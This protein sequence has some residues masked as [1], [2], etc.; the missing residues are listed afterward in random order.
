MRLSG[1]L[2]DEYWQVKQMPY[3]LMNNYV[4]IVSRQASKCKWSWDIVLGWYLELITVSLHI[5]SRA[6]IDSRS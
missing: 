5:Q 4:F 6:Q 2:Q 3:T 1:F